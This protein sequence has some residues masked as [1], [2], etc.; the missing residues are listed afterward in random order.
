MVSR[1][2]YIAVY[3]MASGVRGT[4]YIGVT[5]DLIRRIHEH[6][7][8]L[9]DGFTKTYGCKRLV[10][11][12]PFDTITQAIQREKSLKRYRRDWKLNLIDRENPEWIDLYPAITGQIVD[13]GPLTDL[14]RV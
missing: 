4:L 13:K 9:I 1:D 12:E 10:W 5:S 11:Y 3:I 7:E 2:G 14:P 8:G 6:R